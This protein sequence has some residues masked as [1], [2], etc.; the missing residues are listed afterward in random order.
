MKSILDRGVVAH[1]LGRYV[2]T[3][4]WAAAHAARRVTWA[5][6]AE[7]EHIRISDLVDLMSARQAA[8]LY[9]GDW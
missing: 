6:V 1:A 5:Q 2:P 3:A 7:H 4:V 9:V 8:G